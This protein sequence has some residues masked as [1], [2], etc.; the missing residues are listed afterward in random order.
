MKFSWWWTWEPQWFTMNMTT[1]V[2]C[3]K[4]ENRSNSQRAAIGSGRWAPL[5]WK[6]CQLLGLSQQFCRWRRR[7]LVV[8]TEVP[9][10]PDHAVFNHRTSPPTRPSQLH[11]SYCA[12]FL[13]SEL[14]VTFQE[15]MSVASFFVSSTS[16]TA[17]FLTT[18]ADLSLPGCLI[19]HWS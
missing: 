1:A 11:V 5:F 4:R 13:P 2:V 6:A 16:D 10:L 15:S 12:S 19:D 7:Q 14:L 8:P 9:N 17:H 18:V 3:D